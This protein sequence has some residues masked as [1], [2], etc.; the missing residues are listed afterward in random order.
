MKLSSFPTAACL[1]ASLALTTA[2]RA[3]E[4]ETVDSVLAKYVKALGGKAACEKVTSRVVKV[5]IESDTLGESE[6][7]VFAKVPNKQ[8]AQFD[9][10]DAGTM[11]EGF[12][13][14]VAW[15]KNPWEGL[16]V[17]TGDELA[18]VKR[19]ADFYRDLK[20][21]T[22]YPD[23]ALKGTE[24]VGNEEACVLESRPS[25]TSR[26]KLWFS[27]NTGLLVRQDSEFEGA[28]GPVK[29]NIL[30][31]DYKT[32]DG[33]KYPAKLK[34]K[35]SAGGQD[36]DFTMSFLDVKHNVKIDDAKFVKPAE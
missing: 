7:Q 29:L 34:F 30:P 26:E 19:D 20:L 12:D 3:A 36:F 5:K 16:R 24:K 32:V 1:I 28:Q 10:K 4:K 33:L 21:K 35:I 17:K 15:A 13:G 23:L 9:M 22:L 18:K 6:G 14:K 8:V 25:A 2:A 11:L 27:T 31:Q